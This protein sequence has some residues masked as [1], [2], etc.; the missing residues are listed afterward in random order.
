MTADMCVFSPSPRSDAKHPK[1][2]V[3]RRHERATPGHG[4]PGIP[5]PGG[6]ERIPKSRP[7]PSW[8]HRWLVFDF[9][10]AIVLRVSFFQGTFLLVGV[11]RH[12][13]EN[14]RLR[15]P[16]KAAHVL[17]SFSQLVGLAH[18]FQWLPMFDTWI[19]RSVKLI[20]AALCWSLKDE[21]CAKLLPLVCCGIV[22]SQ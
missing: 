2:T 1:S 11:K 8:L 7:P 12:Q 9:W 19:A 20:Q 15:G 17:F 16:L 21:C 22:S 14:L 13:Q 4:A 3:I 18:A 6:Q 10:G 5:G